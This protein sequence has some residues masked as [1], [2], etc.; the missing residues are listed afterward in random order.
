T[1][2]EVLAQHI[3]NSD[4]LIGAKIDSNGNVV[5]TSIANGMALI[6]GNFTDIVDGDKTINSSILSSTTTVCSALNG[7][8]DGINSMISELNKMAQSNAQSIA[9][10]LN[11]VIANQSS[12]SV[13]TSSASTA[14][15]TS[16]SS[17]T[18]STNTNAT[19]QGNRNQTQTVDR[20]YIVRDADTGSVYANG[21]TESE[22]RS[23]ASSHNY[24]VVG[25]S[26]KAVE[27]RY[28]GRTQ[29]QE[30]KYKIVDRN[31]RTIEDNLTQAQAN[32]KNGSLYSGKGY[33]V[34]AYASGTDNAQKG[35]HLVSEEGEEII[36]TKDGN[37]V[38]A[39]GMQLFPFQGGEVVFDADKTAELLNGSLV[40]LD[41]SQL[42][43]N[44]VTTKLP[45]FS[46]VG[47]RNVGNVV[48]EIH[49]DVNLSGV[50]D[51]NAFIDQLGNALKTNRIEKIVKSISLDELAGRNSL[52]KYKY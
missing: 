46:K 9:S 36:L 33:R 25:T 31:G 29:Q 13:P 3:G 40:P 38:L 22:A 19:P 48:N 21:L 41:A 32:A 24:E 14:S 1:A 2:R 51:P 12:S 49:F 27:V 50:Q 4:M 39:K 44:V 26:G 42:W 34:Q 43:G 10:V 18:P 52:T 8:K 11:Q 28:K 35:F 47:N 23:W 45:D 16:N 37:A 15:N 5:S 6:N 7:I 20:S 30:T 17:N